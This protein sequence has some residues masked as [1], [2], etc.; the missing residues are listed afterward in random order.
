MTNVEIFIKSLNLTWIT[1]F[2]TTISSWIGIF[3]KLL[4]VIHVPINYII[5][6]L[7]AVRQM[8]NASRYNFW[9][10]TLYFLCDFMKYKDW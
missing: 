1:R 5:L 10:K 7:N 8:A 2:L 6:D 3:F 4:G 9:E